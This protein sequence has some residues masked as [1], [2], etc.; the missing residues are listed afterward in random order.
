L[1]SPHFG[2]FFGRFGAPD[3]FKSGGMRSTGIP[4]IPELALRVV[5]TF[6]VSLH[7]RTIGGIE[8]YLL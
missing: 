3:R 6:F 1:K 7:M 2:A 5:S 4:K 8:D